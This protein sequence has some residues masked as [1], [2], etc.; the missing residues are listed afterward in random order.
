MNNDPLQRRMFAQQI[1]AQ[2]ARANQPMGIL[3]SSPQLMGA[4]QGFKDGGEVVKAKDGK[5]LGFENFIGRKLDEMRKAAAEKNTPEALSEK[6]QLKAAEINSR[7][8]VG[9]YN[10]PNLTPYQGRIKNILVT[11]PDLEYDEKT[12]FFR[13]NLESPVV[14]K[15]VKEKQKKEIEGDPNL[16]KKLVKEQE[17]TNVSSDD[18]FTP[19]DVSQG[20]SMAEKINEVNAE[21]NNIDKKEKEEKEGP[22]VFTPTDTDFDADFKRLTKKQ[23][24]IETKINNPKEA[25][26]VVSDYTKR[27][28][29]IDE[30]MK[31]KG[32][33]ITLEDVDKEARK[34]AGLED[35]ARYD[36]DRHTA[37]WMSMIK[38]GLATAAGESSN[39]LTNIAKG[40]SF[41][42][43]S[44]GK[45]INQINENEREDDKTLLNLKYK[46]MSDKKSAEIADRTLKLQ[47]QTA[48]MNAEQKQSQYESDMAYRQDRDKINDAYRGTTFELNLY[49]TMKD[50][51]LGEK[52]FA[53]NVEKFNSDVKYKDKAVDQ[54]EKNFN[55]K[56]SQGLISDEAVKILTMGKKYAT[57]DREAFESGKG[58]V[59]L[60]PLGRKLN[61]LWL[62]GKYQGKMT[63]LMHSVDTAMKSESYL[64]KRFASPEQAKEAT[65]LWIDGGYAKNFGAIKDDAM[66]KPAKERRQDLIDEW[67]SKFTSSKKQG[68]NGD[69]KGSSTG[70]KSN[71]LTVSN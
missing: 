14:E 8:P 65:L 9:G 54:F 1:M 13:S 56:V 53:L 70:F 6:A 71:T 23:K 21:G 37:F 17:K 15:L 61:E 39:A 30:I 62:S 41:G 5:F 3:A 34:M 50:I 36:K 58:G 67:Y 35:N 18:S 43:E 33:D 11:N 47:Y 69:T 19:S 48:L 59:T 44:Y 12:G 64:G 28:Q 60:T 10:N 7:L 38:A 4:V 63:N 68:N 45:D 51:G 66:L 29:K 27:I 49:K 24:D 25:P 2:H 20:S 55:L 42:V 22:K 46:L 57:F 26:K 40:L 32:K 52:T 16:L 31:E